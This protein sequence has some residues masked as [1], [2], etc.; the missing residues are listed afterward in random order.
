MRSEPQHRA[1]VTEAPPSVYFDVLEPGDGQ[2]VATVVMIHGGSH[3][4][5][6]Y[7]RTV[8]GRP[9]WAYVF[10][11][12]G[13]RVVVPDWPG[14]GRSAAVPLDRLTAD[15]VVEGLGQLVASL[16]GPVIL[17]THSMGGALGWRVAEL[18]RERIDRLVAVAPGP[19]GNIMS[20]PKILREAGSEI[21]IE[22]GPIRYSLHLDRW[23][24]NDRD[25]VERKLIGASRFFP[26]HL[27]DAYA[28][29]LLATAPRL[30][31]QRRNVRG[32]Q[33]KVAD[34]R[35]FAGLPILVVTGSEDLDHTREIDGATVDWLKAAGAKAEFLW[36]ADV[37]IVG[38][39]HMLML[40]ENSDAIAER[41]LGWLAG[42]R[43]T[44]SG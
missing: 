30:L 36:L 14:T 43:R 25:F 23:H 20:E 13:Y 44:H 31:Y 8:D 42:G 29:S 1:G 17:L 41:I 15:V 18:A 34:P 9:G 40:E 5:S 22:S 37:G 19:P 16:E 10:A 26:R 6:C 4:G 39:G 7:L 35:R 21:E 24:Q 32:S 3:S 2:A 28:A 38:N 11:R 12:R 27:V 33:V